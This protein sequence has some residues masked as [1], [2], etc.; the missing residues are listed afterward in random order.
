[1][2]RWLG[3]SLGFSLPSLP[4]WAGLKAGQRE[5]DQKTVQAAAPALGLSARGRQQCF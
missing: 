1:M 2:L 3:Q 4:L 5:E